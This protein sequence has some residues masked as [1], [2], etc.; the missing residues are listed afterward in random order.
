MKSNRLI[1]SG[2]TAVVAAWL[3]L[4]QVALVYAAPEAPAPATTQTTPAVTAPATPSTTTTTGP[5][6]PGNGTTDT[7][8]PTCDVSIV[9]WIVCPLINAG[10]ETVNK[11][12]GLVTDMLQVRPLVQN[13]SLYNAWKGLRDLADVAFILVFLV[14]I[15]STALSINIS[16]YQLKTLLPKLIAAAI[17]VQISFFLSSIAID[18]GNVLGAGV[19]R[20]FAELGSTAGSNTTNLS[21]GVSGVGDVLVVGLGAIT[22]IIAGAILTW[23]VV[24]LLLGGMLLSILGVFL[25]LAARQLIIAVLVVTSPLAFVAWILP[26]TQNYFKMWSK[27]LAR[28]ILL[29]PLIV[30]LLSVGGLLARAAQDAGSGPV[31]AVNQIIASLVPIIAFCSIPA[32]FKWAG[33]IMDWAQSKYLMAPMTNANRKVRSSQ[34]M[35]DMKATRKET[36]FLNSRNIETTPDDNKAVAA[37]KKVRRGGARLQAGQLGLG[38]LGKRRLVSGYDAALAAQEKDYM[39]Y[40]DH[41]QWGNGDLYKLATTP[42]GGIFEWKDVYG[43]THTFKNPSKAMRVAAIA[44]WTSSAGNLETSLMMNQIFDDKA[45]NFRGD[46]KPA[47]GMSKKEVVDMWFR[48]LGSGG[49]MA[50]T[51]AAVPAVNPGKGNAVW[52]TMSA[53]QLAGVHGSSTP[54]FY[55]RVMAHVEP[56]DDEKRLNKTATVLRQERIERLVESFTQIAKSRELSGKVDQLLMKRFR[57]AVTQGSYD[58]DP[59]TKEKVSTYNAEFEAIAHQQVVDFNNEVLRGDEFLRKYISPIGKVITIDRSS[60]AGDD[61]PDDE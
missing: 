57:D 53:S 24:F 21:S 26:G 47:F 2:L 39:S 22:A 59:F 9:G 18:I 50:Q 19:G 7:V 43:K 38:R 30:I 6:L 17:L 56:S 27:N 4:G 3:S 28:V 20:I 60:P 14:L 49:A 35:Q 29:Y 44:R 5:Q 32:T 8:Q 13:D 41:E 10:L 52:D 54:F 15:F 46:Y 36:G 12:S 1:L 31:S 51:I 45:N 16:A 40:F 42:N 25:T 48:G 37:F 23:P 33:S 61:V 11:L 34:L 55:D 58:I